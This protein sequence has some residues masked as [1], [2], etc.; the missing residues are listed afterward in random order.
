MSK[1]PFCI[2]RNAWILKR[3]SM[4]WSFPPMHFLYTI[5]KLNITN[6]NHNYIY[7]DHNNFQIKN[8]WLQFDGF[9]LHTIS[10]CDTNNMT[11]VWYLPAMT[12]YRSSTYEEADTQVKMIST[13]DD[14]YRCSAYDEI[15][16][17]EVQWSRRPKLRAAKGSEVLMKHNSR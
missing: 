5:T 14:R 13:S 15:G 16:S 10:Y 9:F 6:V 7:C 11:I 17:Q 3:N 12:R 2:I 8:A 1:Q 4:V